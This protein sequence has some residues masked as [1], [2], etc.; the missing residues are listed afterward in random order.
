MVAHRYCRLNETS[1]QN[2]D[3]H[4]YIYLKIWGIS[5]AI[6]HGFIVVV[7][8]K[9]RFSKKRKHIEPSND[10]LKQQ[11]RWIEQ[12]AN[13]SHLYLFNQNKRKKM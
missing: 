10:W 1:K 11:E 8:E 3:I 6:F 5:H 9:R 13:R 7:M 4:V 12:R 2:D